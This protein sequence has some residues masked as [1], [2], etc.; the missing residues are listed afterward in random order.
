MSRDSIILFKHN[1]PV[2]LMMPL[3]VC[4]LVCLCKVVEVT[5]LCKNEYSILLYKIVLSQT[6]NSCMKNLWFFVIRNSHIKKE[7]VIFILFQLLGMLLFY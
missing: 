5:R 3:F 2:F 4:L 6:C 7:C 1:K